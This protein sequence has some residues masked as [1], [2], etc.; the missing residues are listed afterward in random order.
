MGD[1][2]IDEDPMLRANAIVVLAGAPFERC[3]EAARLYKQDVA[4]KIIT[5][6]EYANSSAALMNKAVLDDAHLGRIGLMN[7]GIDS[8]KIMAIAQ[9]TSTYEEA[10]VMLAYAKQ[11]NYK[12]IVV[13][14]TLHHS[15]RVHSVFAKKFKN[16][17]IEVIV[18]GCPP[19]NY[20]PEK[21]WEYEE[22]MMFVVNEYIKWVYYIFKGRIF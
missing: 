3:A 1:F 18:R 19:L 22:G 7:M 17:G 5:T 6:G 14:T 2:L 4:G 9:G 13:V 16:S 12:R 8:T 15:H 11:E 21:W 10:R 20:K